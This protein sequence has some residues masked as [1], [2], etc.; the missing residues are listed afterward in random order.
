MNLAPTTNLWRG[1]DGKGTHHSIWV[2]L[3]DLGDE[4]CTH[5]GTGTTTK[6]VSDLE[7]LKTVGRLCLTTDDVEDGVNELSTWLVLVSD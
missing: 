6:G 3:S 2:F 5:T 7:T 4:Q 1:D